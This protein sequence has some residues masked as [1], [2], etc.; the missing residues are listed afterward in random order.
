MRDERV[1]EI[2]GLRQV[3][4]GLEQALDRRRR[5]QVRAADDHRYPC[6]RIVDDAG[7]VIRCRRVLPREDRVADLR[8][9]GGK[10]LSVGLRPRR[11]A[12]EFERLA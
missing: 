9:V 7:E 5:S 3:E 6:R 12:R 8:R 2:G 10:A 11:Q 4:Q 1:M